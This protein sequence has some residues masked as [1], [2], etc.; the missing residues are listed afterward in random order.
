MH[1]L[2][3][4]FCK[5]FREFF[6][7]VFFLQNFLQ[8]SPFIKSPKRKST[9]FINIFYVNVT[10]KSLFTYKTVPLMFNLYSSRAL[11]LLLHTTI[12]KAVETFGY[13]SFTPY[14]THTY[15]LHEPLHKRNVYIY[16]MLNIQLRIAFGNQAANDFQLIIFRVIVCRIQNE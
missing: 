13:S 11:K 1:L 8:I 16:K 9:L 3:K 4:N 15:T 10:Q 5:T 6:L 12:A 14:L 7:S 2:R